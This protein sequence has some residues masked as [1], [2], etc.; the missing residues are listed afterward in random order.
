MLAPTC[1]LLVSVL[2][3]ALR[4]LPVALPGLVHDHRAPHDLAL[5]ATMAD[6]AV[7]I[8]SWADPKHVTARATKHLSIRLR[9]LVTH[10]SASERARP[11]LTTARPSGSFR[12]VQRPLAR[13]LGIAVPGLHLVRV[14]RRSRRTCSRTSASSMRR[15]SLQGLFPDGRHFQSLPATCPRSTTVAPV[16]KA[17]CGGSKTEGTTTIRSRDR[18]APA[19]STPRHVSRRPLRGSL[20]RSTK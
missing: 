5:V 13:G 17:R 7:A 20:R 6:L 15:A 12:R 2:V 18:R 11:A 8:A 4:R 3:L 10:A 9:T 19:S 1:P 16:A 14:R